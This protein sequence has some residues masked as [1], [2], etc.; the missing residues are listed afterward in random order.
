MVVGGSGCERE[1]LIASAM[2]KLDSSNL[3]IRLVDS[4]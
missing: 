3:G 2:G 1:S 4:P